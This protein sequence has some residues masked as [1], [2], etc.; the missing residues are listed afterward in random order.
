MRSLDFFATHP[1]FRHEEFLE[2]RAASGRSVHTSNNLLAQHLGNG[3]LLR[4]RR[5]LYAAVPRGVDP[6]QVY[7]DPYLVA[8]H[9]A[10][11]AVVA[12][13][14]ALQFFGKAHSLWRRF[15]YLTH[16]RLRP[17]SVRGLEFV[18]VQAPAAVRSRPDWGGQIIEVE[19]AGGQV[20]VTTLER[21]LVDVLTEPSRGGSWEEIWRSL[22]MIEYCDLDAVI[23]Y[24]L[25]LG[26]ALTAGRVGFFL[27]QHRE[28]WMVEETHLE[29]LRAH[30]PAQ[31]RYFDRARQPGRLVPGWNLIVP[32]HI[33]HR[34]WEEAA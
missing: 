32:E 6:A 29:A 7:V 5:G 4:V 2:A 1:V 17:F 23:A 9:V 31:P 20:R 14:A 8:S 33:L 21:T 15:H 3:R 12:Y 11:D 22:E 18:G 28:N 24:T 30:A 10:D 27:E 16:N 26:S 34:G 19:H 25:T 13:H